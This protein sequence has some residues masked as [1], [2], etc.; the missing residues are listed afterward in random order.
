MSVGKTRRIG[1]ILL[2]LLTVLWTGFILCRSLKPA[3]ESDAESGRFLQL[4]RHII[5]GL[6]MHAVR[7]L[8]HFTEY[9]LLGLLA[10]TDLRLIVPKRSWLCLAY[11]LAVAIA[12]ESIQR[13]VP[14]RSGQLSDVLLDLSGAAAAFG[15]C[16]LIVLRKKKRSKGDV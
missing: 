10:W 9:F 16:C 2:L 7:K 3:V 6:T 8:A 14:G 15:L 11:A 1:L 5:P 12:D 13:F 4:L